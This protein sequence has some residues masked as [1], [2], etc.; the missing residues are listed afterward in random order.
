M[1]TSTQSWNTRLATVILVGATLAWIVLLALI[2]LLPVA[3]LRFFDAGHVKFFLSFASLVAVSAAAF[4]V[5]RFFYRPTATQF[6]GWLVMMLI[7][8]FLPVTGFSII[9]WPLMATFNA[10]GGLTGSISFGE[11]SSEAWIIV[12]LYLSAMIVGGYLL[13]HVR[14]VSKQLGEEL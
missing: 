2:L 8:S 12:A 14:R 4:S 13:F 1:S 7:A 9:A 3:T 5:Y 10:E 6:F 11:A